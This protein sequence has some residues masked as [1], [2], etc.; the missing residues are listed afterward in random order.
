MITGAARGI[1]LGIARVLA[2]E[3]A[4]VA[5]ADIDRDAATAAAHHLQGEGCDA[6]AV[7][8]D[9]VDSASENALVATV[10]EQYGRLDVLATNAGIYSTLELSV[11][12]DGEWDAVMNVNVKGVT[13][14]I[15]AAL[16]S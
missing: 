8:V 2:R 13:H 12:T 7:Q 10:I 9:V 6:L 16:P 11:V 15:Q 14:S 5:I 1:G 4:R 3:R